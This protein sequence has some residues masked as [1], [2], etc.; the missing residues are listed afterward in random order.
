M[1]LLARFL[2]DGCGIVLQGFDLVCIRLVFFL[3]T[4]ISFCRPWYSARFC[5][6]TTMPL[7]PNITC[8]KST[9]RGAQRPALPVG[10]GRDRTSTVRD[11][12]VSSGT[13]GQA[14]ACGARAASARMPSSGRGQDAKFAALVLFEDPLLW[15]PR[16][17]FAALPGCGASEYTRTTGSVPESR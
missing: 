10:G 9:R 12:G 8:R 5:R 14:S 16:S 1:Q 2:L 17:T 4:S 13:L 6:Y 7:A 11:A 3:Q 15:L